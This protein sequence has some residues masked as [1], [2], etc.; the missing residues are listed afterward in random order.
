MTSRLARLA[1]VAA[2]LAAGLLLAPAAAAQT[3]YRIDPDR[4]E[5]V[6]SMSHPAHDWT[7]ES[8]RVSGTLTVSGST[9]TGGRVQAPVQS[10]T[11][12][13]RNRD[14]HM[15]ETTES[16]LYPNVTFEAR[17]VTMLPAAER[18]ADRNATVQGVLTFHDVARPVTVPVLV[19]VANGA[20]R[21][22]GAFDVTLTEFGMDRPSLLGI[23]TRDWVGLRLDLTARADSSS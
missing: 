2:T 6:Y 22:T 9:V 17:T 23:K 21:V 3:T 16:Y 7:G 12:G 20:A 14:S 1:A 13:N 11:S 15:A 19:S 8:H 18:T 5:I 4:S 10:F